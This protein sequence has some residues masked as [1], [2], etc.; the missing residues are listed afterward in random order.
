[1][2]ELLCTVQHTFGLCMVSGFCR[3]VDENCTLRV[4]MQQLVVISYQC[5]W[6]TYQSLLYP[7]CTYSVHSGN[8]SQ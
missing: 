3:Q 4:I 5:F 1:M 6:T 2:N 8:L 7:C